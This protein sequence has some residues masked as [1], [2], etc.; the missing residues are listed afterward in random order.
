MGSNFEVLKEIILTEKSNFLSAELN[1]YTFKVC[2]CA[3]K[4]SIAKAIEFL[5]KVKVSSVNI[6]NTCGKF[7][8]ARTRGALPGK[9]QSFKKAIV[10]LKEGNKIEIM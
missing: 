6:L 5:F 1:K 3:T 2:N 8:R 9:T 10:S 4:S 7:K